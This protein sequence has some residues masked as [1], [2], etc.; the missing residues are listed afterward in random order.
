MQFFAEQPTAARC[1]GRVNPTTAAYISGL[2]SFVID[3]AAVI[4]VAFWPVPA[5]WLIAILAGITFTWTY[6]MFV[7]GC[8]KK[9]VIMVYPYVLLQ[10]FALLL[11]SG[12][13]ITFLCLTI[14]ACS[15][16][17]GPGEFLVL[18]ISAGAITIALIVPVYGLINY[19]VYLHR[20][21]RTEAS[22]TLP[23]FAIPNGTWTTQPY[24]QSQEELFNQPPPDYD[25]LMAA[26]S[27]VQPRLEENQPREVSIKNRNSAAEPSK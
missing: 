9:N 22:P 17:D 6:A 26:N 19:L 2:A 10:I 7:F 25:V 16:D 1:C 4:C 5:R 8:H 23:K 12:V 11:I 20:I 13:F 14:M 24:A 3:V 21:K 18:A 27:N 15:D